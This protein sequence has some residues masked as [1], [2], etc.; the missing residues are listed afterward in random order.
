MVILIFGLGAALAILILAL[1]FLAG[2]S[3]MFASLPNPRYQAALYLPENVRAVRW[4]LGEAQALVVTR[5][6]QGQTTPSIIFVPGFA[7]DYRYGLLGLSDWM[8]QRPS[9][10]LTVLL[11]RGYVN[12]FFEQDICLQPFP[13]TLAEGGEVFT[14]EEDG[15]VVRALIDNDPSDHIV[16]WGHSQGG[17][18][19]QEAVTDKQSDGAF[20]LRTKLLDR[21]RGLVLEGSVLPDSGFCFLLGL[22]KFKSWVIPG[23]NFIPVGHLLDGVLIFKA[24]DNLRRIGRRDALARISILDR[25]LYRFRK[26]LVALDNGWSNKAFVKET[27]RVEVLKALHSKDRLFGLFPSKSDLILDTKE[28]LRVIRQSCGLSPSFVGSDGPVMILDQTHFVSLE[29]PEIAADLLARIPAFMTSPKSANP[30]LETVK[31]PA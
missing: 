3:R 11:K 26:P 7:E 31:G 8:E 9:F 20:A 22:P 6:K 29:R 24:R 5:G 21:V 27:G 4:D 10:R 19:I 16:L 14:I 2:W 25:C 12:P 28:N 1:L 15:A 30:E 18:V 23:L 17:A 13:G